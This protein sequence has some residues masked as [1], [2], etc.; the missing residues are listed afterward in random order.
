MELQNQAQGTMERV[1]YFVTVPYFPE[2]NLDL[3]NIDGM[4]IEPGGARS[5]KEIC[6]ELSYQGAEDLYLRIELKD[7]QNGIRYTRYKI[8]NSTEHQKIYWN[9]RDADSY[10]FPSDNDLD[11]HKAK[12]LIFIIERNNFGDYIINSDKGSINFHRIW[13][14]SDKSET[15]P[16]SDEE[17]IDL[18][19]RRTYQY[20]LDWS[21]RKSPSLGIPQDRSNFGDLLTVG[22]IG[23]ALPLI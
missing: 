4:L 19:E 17:Y 15:K 12:Q 10:S 16:Q 7:T 14:S 6:L 20:F 2:Y 11:L 9:F 18:V 21:S 8:K 22:G 23:F 1:S 5:F 13:F 3:D